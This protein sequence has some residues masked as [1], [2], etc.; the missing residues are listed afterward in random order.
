ML[1]CEVKKGMS[2]CQVQRT[3]VI[4]SHETVWYLYYRIRSAMLELNR[5]MLDGKVEVDE[6][7]VGGKARGIGQVA[8]KAKKQVAIGIR[9]RGGDLR[10]FHA[11]DVKSGT[12][13]LHQGKRQRRC[14]RAVRRRLLRLPERNG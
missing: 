11:K 1:L 5:P 3:L 14:R 8:A 12:L 9:Q 6:T 13:T 7:F 2:A 4:G 10:F